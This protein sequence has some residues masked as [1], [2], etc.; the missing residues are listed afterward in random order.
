[1]SGYAY[2]CESGYVCIFKFS[3]V[4]QQAT[5]KQWL[6]TVTIISSSP[7]QV[8]ELTELSWVVLSWGRSLQHCSQHMSGAGII[9]RASSHTCPRPALEK[10]AT[11]GASLFLFGLSRSLFHYGG[12]SVDEFLTRQVTAKAGRR[13]LPNGCCDR[14]YSHSSHYPCHLPLVRS[15]SQVPTTLVKRETTQRCD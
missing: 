3:I 12:F 14:T 11:P 10:Q 6:K 8:W 2:E 5:P 1:M 4:T 15:T 9:L 7:T 13:T